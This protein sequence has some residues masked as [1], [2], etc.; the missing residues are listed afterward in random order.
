MNRDQFIGTPPQ[1]DGFS[2]D[3]M[4]VYGVDDSS[5]M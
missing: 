1:M 5:L 3:S 4:N 2:E